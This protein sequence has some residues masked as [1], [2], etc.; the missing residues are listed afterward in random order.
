MC[1]RVDNEAGKIRM[2]DESASRVEY[3]DDPVLSGALRLDELAEGVELEIGR[4][5]TG[6]L[7]SQ[8]CADRYHRRADAERDI[9]C[10]DQRS[11]SLHRVA[12]PG[13]LARV[14][15]IPPQIKLSD[16]VV[17][18][19]FKNSAHG[20]VAARRRANQIDRNRRSGH[21]TQPRPL[22]VIKLANAAHL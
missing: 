22:V 7:T 20:Q 6:N 13:P 5:D 3:R 18:P 9:R 16:L 1:H 15:S 4:N 21:R 11:V 10:R 17:V 14:V 2:G 12:I 8:R 19:I